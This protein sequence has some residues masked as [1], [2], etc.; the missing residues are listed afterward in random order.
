MLI[1]IFVLMLLGFCAI[2]EQLRCVLA[3][4]YKINKIEK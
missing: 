4:L 2:V 1:A 3:E